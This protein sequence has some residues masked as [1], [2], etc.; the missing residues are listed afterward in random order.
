MFNTEEELLYLDCA[1]LSQDLEDSYHSYYRPIAL[2]DFTSQTGRQAPNYDWMQKQLNVM[3][4]VSRKQELGRL[5]GLHRYAKQCH[6]GFKQSTVV[7]YL[8][9]WCTS[10]SPGQDFL[11]KVVKFDIASHAP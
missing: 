5:A 10:G 4:R 9:G 1:T 6:A 7:T 8:D 3:M 11:A 2:A